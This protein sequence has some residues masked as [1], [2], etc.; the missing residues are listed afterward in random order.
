MTTGSRTA[1]QATRPAIAECA[2]P[3]VKEPWGCAHCGL[4][5]P[6]GRPFGVYCCPGCEVVHGLLA[7][8]GLARF[9]ELGGGRGRP[10]GAAPRVGD[11]GWLSI[12]EDRAPRSGDGDAAVVQV[13]VDVQ[14]I[15]CAAC[16]WLLQQVWRRI[17]GAIRFE[18]NP[19]LGRALVGYTRSKGTLAEFVRQAASFGYR[20]GPAGK[21]E[22]PAD[23]GLLL[24]LGIC[25]ALAMNAMMFAFAIYSGMSAEDG[26][27]FELFHWLA[28]AIATAAVLVGGPVFFRAALAGLR[29]RVLHLDLPISL[30]ILLAWT[31]ST[32]VFLAG[33]AAPYFDTV[34][35]FVALMLA[36]RFV[37]R[38]AVRRNRDY[39][40]ANDG[41]EHLRVRRV[42]GDSVESVPVRELTQ[43]DV[44]LLAP[45]DLV[46]ADA[47]LD[48]EEA[49]LSLDWVLGESRARSF[50]RGEEV[51][52]GAFVASRRPVRVV[53]LRT[54]EDSGLLRLLATPRAGARESLRGR[55]RF[56]VILNRSWVAAVL[57][58]ASVAALAWSFVDPVVAAQVATAVLVITCPC[59][60]GLATPLAF[61][62]A[63]AG[64]RRRGIFIRDGAMLEKGRHVR[65]VVFDKTGT[66]T[67]GGV[68]VRV[69][70]AVPPSL[71]NAL[72][73]LATS[74]NHPVSDAVQRALREN[75]G[76][77]DAPRLDA[78]L[79]D[80]EELV[81]KG[82][83]ARRGDDELRLGSSSF[84]LGDA[85][86]KGDESL[87]LFVRN[88]RVEAAFAVEEDY[89]AGA[90][91]EL[92]GLRE[93][94]YGVVLLSGDRPER[95]RRA[96]VD[97]G[98]AADDVHG[99]MR[100]EDKAAFVRGIDHGDT[101]VVGDGLND[102]P[103]FEAAF[104]AGTPALDRPVMPERADFFY[105]G[106]GIGAVARVLATARGFH[107]L[108]RRNLVI[109]TTYNVLAVSLAVAGLMTP[110]LCAVLMPASSIAL[111]AHTVGVAKAWGRP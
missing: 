36:G 82:V 84:T 50:V 71:R 64:L 32:V 31:S 61:D 55:D 23:R 37:Q 106:G 76:I 41:A 20:V 21:A 7:S 63:V 8:E 85:E 66:L 91:E 98:F 103:A 35:I 77:A 39:L 87:C 58:I 80:V 6:S 45:G 86:S 12:L 17:P 107:G 18:L 2:T 78:G 51:P 24:R 93:H 5:L 99:G 110:L 4:P 70:R 25:A 3:I 92:A 10:I 38:R 27:N 15:H 73:T 67:W 97:L 54:P 13:Q 60:V 42:A 34:T 109:A 46:P 100:P 26:A 43:G 94:G 90:T 75:G 104:C 68:R 14:G 81:G 1:S 22:D 72:F 88:G 65:T 44:L 47:A 105:T 89:R 57:T 9:Y 83:R 49:A 53:V 102:A 52:A 95:V 11:L 96:A 19:S 111:I 28:F 56:W 79:R 40:L 69:V 29:Q 59:A 62:M 108:V 74:S 16:V 33:L 48:V 30:G 101:L